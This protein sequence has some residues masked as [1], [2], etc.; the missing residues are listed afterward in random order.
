MRFCA[1]ASILLDRSMP[2]TRP[3]R[4][5][6]DEVDAGADAHFEHVRARTDAHLLDRFEAARMERR[7]IGVV[8][9]ACAMFW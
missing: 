1:F 9:D 6:S 5:Y 3:L 2:V 8:V 4:G 7:P